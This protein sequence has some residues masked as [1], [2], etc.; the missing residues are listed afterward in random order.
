M[1]DT[2]IK[3]TLAQSLY[4]LH[5]FLNPRA[6]IHAHMY[7]PPLSAASLYIPGIMHAEFVSKVIRPPG[8]ISWLSASSYTLSRC[9]RH[10]LVIGLTAPLKKRR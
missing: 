5:T 6:R 10:R 9:G 2:V 7:V 4:D 8:L 1:A 3:Q